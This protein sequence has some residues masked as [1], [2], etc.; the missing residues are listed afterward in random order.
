VKQKE[1]DKGSKLLL[2]AY[3]I[4]RYP[5]R[6]DEPVIDERGAVLIDRICAIWSGPDS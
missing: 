5:D 3:L 2:N 4:D 6:F 1:P